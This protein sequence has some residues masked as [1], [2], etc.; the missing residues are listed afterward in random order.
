L[1]SFFSESNLLMT[2]ISNLTCE[3]RENPTGIDI[4]QPRFCWQM[5]TDRRGARQ[6]AYQLLMA[7]S[8]DHLTPDD[9]DIWNS[10]KVMSDQSVHVEYDG[11]TLNSRQQVYWRVIVWDETD[12]HYESET[13][14]FEMGLLS[15]D[16]W[17]ASWIGT[18]VI[19]GVRSTIPAPYLRTTFNL[20]DGVASARL[21]VTALGV[22]ECRLNGE[23]V[24]EDVFAPGWTDYNKRIQYLTYDV[25]DMLQVGENALGAL[26]GDGWAVGYV[27]W[28][29]RQNYTDRPQLLAQLEITLD[30][31][32]TRKITTDDTWCYQFG[33]I[34]HSDFLMV[35]AYDARR[36]LTGWDTADYDASDWNP[37][38]TLPGPSAL[39]VAHNGPTVRAVQNLTPIEDPHDTSGMGRTRY[40]F[41]LGQNMVGRVRFKGADQEGRTITIRFAEVL[42]PDGSPYFTNLRTAQATDY[43]TFKGDGEEVWESH[44]TFHGFRYVEIEGYEGPISRETITGIVLHSDMQQTGTFECSDPLLNQLQSNILWGQK[45]NF[46]ELPTDCPQR[47]ERLGWTGD[48]QVFAET[49]AFNMDIAE[50]G[51]AHV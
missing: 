37:V 34:T 8:P 49:A 6:T 14:W 44:F 19:G 21:Y 38:L 45:G 17:S 25:T 33:P 5:Q 28:V 48:I 20:P 27:A 12:S 10:G 39:L 41:D 15:A 40:L 42:N 7:N 16:D 24:G 13:A 3:Y 23:R 18:D 29:G 50:I 11:T 51:R 46:L 26:L 1:S 32:T 22:F 36:E 9:A 35:E 31:G 2:L 47:D 4:T 43:Y 30:D